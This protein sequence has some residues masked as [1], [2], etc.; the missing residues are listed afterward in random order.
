MNQ[1]RQ[2]ICLSCGHT[3]EGLQGV[4]VDVHSYQ[5]KVRV[6]GAGPNQ[7][8]ADWHC[9]QCGKANAALFGTRIRES[10][11]GPGVAALPHVIES[12]AFYQKSRD[13][14]EASIGG[15]PLPH[16]ELITILGHWL[17]D[18]LLGLQ[19]YEPWRVNQAAPA[20]EPKKGLRHYRRI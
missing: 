19:K 15:L 11:L 14:F 8:G 16:P 12:R 13:N 7:T 10:D 4:M 17:L 2:I 20:I 9:P 18:R 1:G 5:A 3:E 6:P